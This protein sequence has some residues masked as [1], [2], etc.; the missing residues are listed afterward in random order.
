MK[1]VK[2]IWED[3]LFIV[4]TQ[5]MHQR[6]SAIIDGLEKKYFIGEYNSFKTNPPQDY[7]VVIWLDSRDSKWNHGYF[8]WSQTKVDYAVKWFKAP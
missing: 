6:E 5:I 3:V 4:A 2:K 8:V 7:E 1:T